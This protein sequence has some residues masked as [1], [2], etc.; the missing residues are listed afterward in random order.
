MLRIVASTSSVRSDRAPPASISASAVACTWECC[1]T[2]SSAR[3]NPKVST[4]QIRCCSSP[5][6]CRTA[7]ACT[8]ESCASSRSVSRSRGRAVGEVEV[9]PPGGGDPAGHEQQPLPVGLPRGAGRHLGDQ[10]GEVALGA[11]EGGAQ[12]RRERGALGGHGHRAADAGG[13]VL[14]RDQHVLVL[15]QQG[16]TRDLGGHVG[17]AVAVA[18][19]PGA[20]ADVGAGDRRAG[21]GARFERAVERPVDQRHRPEERL[22]EGRHGGPHLVERVELGRAELGGP[23]QQVDLLPQPPLGLLLLAG[24]TTRGVVEVEV[25]TDPLDRGHHRPPPR[26]GRVGRQHRPE[27]QVPDEPVELLGPHV[28]AERAHRLGQRLGHRHVVTVALPQDADAVVLLGQVGEVEVAREGPR[29]QHGAVDRP[30]GDQSRH[31][32]DRGLASAG[33]D[34]RFAQAFDIGQRSGPPS[35]AIACPRISPRRRTSARRSSGI[36]VTALWRSS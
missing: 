4:C 17:V 3:W 33:G 16:L 24:T 20:V 19:D 6:A 35:S 1:R 27:L 2:S 31:V 36:S 8:S 9:A 28:V 23:P 26:L 11:G 13:R 5:Y 7:P 18:A 32:V 12:L 30:I 10:V 15:D 34:H 25:A 22:V 29:D 14:Q 21:A